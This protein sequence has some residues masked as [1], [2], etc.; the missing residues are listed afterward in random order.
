[1]TNI[2]ICGIGGKMGRMLF[3]TAQ[4]IKDINIVGGVDKYCGFNYDFPVFENF[5]N[6]NILCD[7]VIDFSRPEALKDI[8]PY[9]IKNKIPAVLASTG[10]DNN[11][12]KMI[13]EASKK[14]AIFQS[15][16]MSLGVNLLCELIKHAAKFLDGFDIE[17]IEKH[18]NK[19]VDSPSG[20]ALT[21]ANSVNSVFDGRKKYVYGRHSMSQK[22]QSDEI[23]I[24]AIRGGSVVGEH[25]VLFLGN[26]ETVTLSHKAQSKSVFAE[27]ALKA[28]QFIKNKPA[29]IYSMNDM[30]NINNI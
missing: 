18:H 11:H 29:G 25:D 5:D 23:G 21:L 9:C 22:R 20:T 19:K 7:A 6:C 28:S 10:Y 8:L 4:E 12:N 27:G 30:L 14:V 13:E 15:S 2:I 16:N 3:D 26:D 1:M 24:H 17:I